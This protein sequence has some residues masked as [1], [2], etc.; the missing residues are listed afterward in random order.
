MAPA[1]MACYHKCFEP[2][3]ESLGKN[4]IVADLG[5]F[6]VIFFFI[7]KMVYCVYSLFHLKGCCVF[8]LEFSNENTQHAYFAS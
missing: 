4:P 6:R 1:L 2:I 3:L 8:S 5:K 7:L